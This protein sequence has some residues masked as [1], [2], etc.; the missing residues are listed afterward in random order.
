MT[1]IVMI[2]VLS[3][4]QSV[5]ISNVTSSGMTQMDFPSSPLKRGSSEA[6]QYRRDRSFTMADTDEETFNY[7]YNSYFKLYIKRPSFIFFTK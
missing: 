4:P 7:N 1:D 3:S 2:P 5:R 6:T